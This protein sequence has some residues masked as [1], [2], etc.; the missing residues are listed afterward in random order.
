MA[1]A[2]QVNLADNLER[3]GVKPERILP[4]HSRIATIAELYQQI[5]R[6]QP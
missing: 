2:N 6:K 1:N 5:G 3:L 4:L